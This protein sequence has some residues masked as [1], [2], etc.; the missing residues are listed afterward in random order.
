M[1][2]LSRTT[3]SAIPSGLM[4]GLPHM[5]STSDVIGWLQKQVEYHIKVLEIPL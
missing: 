2:E 1:S 5:L 3:L 4:S